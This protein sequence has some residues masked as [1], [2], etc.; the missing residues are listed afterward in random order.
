M[1]RE[2]AFA[3]AT[4]A[5]VAEQAQLRAKYA[6]TSFAPFGPLAPQD[7]AQP[8]IHKV[9]V[10]LEAIG[11][12]KFDAD[13]P[14]SPPIIPLGTT[15]GWSVTVATD[16]V[17]DALNAAGFTVQRGDRCWAGKIL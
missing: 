14:L 17:I 10:A 9:I 4:A 2:E 15:D 1:R 7:W 3:K 5:L 6:D 16:M 12:V 8:S 11:L 13:T